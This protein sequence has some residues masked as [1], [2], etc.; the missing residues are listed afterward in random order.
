[1]PTTTGMHWNNSIDDI[2]S[3]I[4]RFIRRFVNNDATA[5]DLAN[6]VF[7]DAWQKASQFE[8]RSKVTSWLLAIGRFKALSE[9]RKKRKTVDPDE[10]LGA[11]EDPSDNPEVIA[12]KTDKGNA[13]KECIKML[14][15]DHRVIIDLVYYHERS[16]KEA[17]GILE[18]PE[19]TVKTR[20]FHARKNLSA[21]MQQ[22]GLD[23]GWP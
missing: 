7:L 21:L 11:M 19:N 3:E 2:M 8:G 5:E 12:Q 22:R 1:M 14:S 6:D 20:M 13:L 10:A 17:A 18:I 4:Y 15:E 16:I 23:R 9:H